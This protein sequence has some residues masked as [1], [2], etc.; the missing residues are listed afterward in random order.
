M[1]K[2]TPIKAIRQK[3]LE[4][5]NYQPKEVRLCSVKNCAL[6]VYRDGHRPKDDKSINEEPSCEKS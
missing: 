1:A 4:C 5:S 3:C 6:Y 2:L